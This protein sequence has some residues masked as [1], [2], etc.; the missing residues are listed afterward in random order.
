VILFLTDSD[1]DDVAIDAD[2][3]YAVS[4]GEMKRPVGVRP[5]PENGQ[6]ADTHRVTLVHCLGGPLIVSQTWQAVVEAWQ[7]G[8]SLRSELVR[9]PFDS[10]ARS[11][12]SVT[13]PRGVRPMEDDGDR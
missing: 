7:A 10:Q 3:I 4:V 8:Q 1:G 12:R 13:A 2:A 6:P 9:D 5:A 11:G